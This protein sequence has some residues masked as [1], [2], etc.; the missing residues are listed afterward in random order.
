MWFS[1]LKIQN[2]FGLELK[3]YNGFV[4]EVEKS[5]MGLVYGLKSPKWIW[6]NSSKVGLGV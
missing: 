2:K 5:K 4:L 3:I 6:F 1:G